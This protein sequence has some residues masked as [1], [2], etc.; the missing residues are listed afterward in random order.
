MDFFAKQLE[1]K[2]ENKVMTKR[3]Y[4]KTE[5]SPDIQFMP[6]CVSSNDIQIEFVQPFER[7]PY[8]EIIFESEVRSVFKSVTWRNDNNGRRY[9]FDAGEIKR[10]NI[11]VT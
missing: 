1:M 8:L 10:L 6:R 3:F 7:N 11:G 9:Q 5:S 2:F 4:K